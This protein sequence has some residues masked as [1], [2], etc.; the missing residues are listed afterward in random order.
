MAAWR[1]DP[2]AERG[3]HHHRADLAAAHLP[4]SAAGATRGGAPGKRRPPPPPAA[5]SV[6]LGGRSPSQSGPIGRG[7]STNVTGFRMGSAARTASVRRR[8]PGPRPPVAR[9]EARQR[10]LGARVHAPAAAAPSGKSP[11]RRPE[12]PTPRSPPRSMTG[13]RPRSG[14]KLGDKTGEKAGE[15]LSSSPRLHRRRGSDVRSEGGAEPPASSAASSVTEGRAG[16]EPNDR[17]AK[18]SG[19]F[20]LPAAA[21]RRASSWV[22][23]AVAASAQ[24][25]GTTP[26]PPIA[27]STV[28]PPPVAA[29]ARHPGGR[30]GSRDHRRCRACRRD[31]ASGSCSSA[32]AVSLAAVLIIGLSI[33]QCGGDHRSESG[34]QATSAAR[35]NR[36]RPPAAAAP[37]VA[38]RSVAPVTT[39]AIALVPVVDALR[40]D[41]RSAPAPRRFRCSRDAG[42]LIASTPPPASESPVPVTRSTEPTTSPPDGGAQGS[43]RAVP[44][45]GSGDESPTRVAATAPRLPS[46]RRIASAGE[47]RTVTGQRRWRQRRRNGWRASEQRRAGPKGG[48]AAVEHAGR[49]PG[50]NDAKSRSVRRRS[51]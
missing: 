4:A 38:P 48:R 18:R 10:R 11:A 12:H 39:P 16:D 41:R 21:S 33:R 34:R 19:T 17:S 24:R 40:R 36:A 49:R 6:G 50:R 43:G 51:R 44:P 28:P 7:P 5:M 25:A 47:R 31:T 9:S 13:A 42:A 2:R 30:F 29:A 46:P 26:A 37:V 27:E 22:A 8:R 23:E 20:E 3:G 15:G 35:D 1:G 14:Q 45:A 32:V